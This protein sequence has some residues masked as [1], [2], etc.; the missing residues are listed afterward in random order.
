MAEVPA[1]GNLVRAECLRLLAGVAVGRV[2]FTIGAMPA[3]QPV[4]YTLVKDEVIFQAAAGSALALASHHAVVA[5]QA[6]DIDPLSN[7]GWSVVGVG[8]AYEIAEPTLSTA[9]DT[10]A[11]TIAIP[12][13]RLTGHRLQLT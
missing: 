7:A 9:F 10:G 8:Q 5:F 6:D 3:A 13:Q 1:P 2:V 11:C 12:L 4:A